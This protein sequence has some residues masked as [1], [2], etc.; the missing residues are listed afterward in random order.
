MEE[1]VAEIVG[2]AGYTELTVL[3]L[4]LDEGYLRLL[5]GG[6]SDQL[7]EVYSLSLNGS[8]GGTGR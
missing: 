1:E 6:I 2:I 3:I 7:I 5:N 4:N 8:D